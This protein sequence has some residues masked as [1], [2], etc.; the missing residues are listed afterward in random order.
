MIAKISPFIALIALLAL[1]A[2]LNRGCRQG[3]K[4]PPISSAEQGAGFASPRD[5]GLGIGDIETSLLYEIQLSPESI[6]DNIIYEENEG[7]RGHVM[8]ATLNVGAPRPEELWLMATVR[9]TKNFRGHTVLVKPH[10][11]V[12][13][14]SIARKSIEMDDVI[15]SD[16]AV[17]NITIQR[18]DL[19][20]HLDEIPESVLVTGKLDIY[21]F[22]N[23]PLA[24]ADLE[25]LDSFPPEMHTLRT[26]NPVRVNFNF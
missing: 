2:A 26:A 8:S 9:S 19:M 10:F 6:A 15:M 4:P 11:Y 25:N 5:G 17:T 16:D 18:V 14:D 7:T 1:L 22:K 21:Y 23:T 13:G 3:P 12:S 24:E 20:A